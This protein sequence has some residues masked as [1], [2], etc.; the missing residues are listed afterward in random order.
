MQPQ[1]DPTKKELR[2]WSKKI[3]NE[4]QSNF[5]MIPLN[6]L[7]TANYSL[8]KPFII[9]LE[10]DGDRYMASLDDIEAFAVSD[11]E[12]EAING[13]CE[14]IVQLYEDLFNSPHKLGPLPQKWLQFLNDY[15]EKR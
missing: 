8:K 13:L 6:S 5:R 1:S 2:N 9:L 7:Q 4:I 10:K 3:I 11:T 15:I 12:Y 14:E